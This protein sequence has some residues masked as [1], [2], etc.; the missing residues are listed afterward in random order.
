L[1]TPETLLLGSRLSLGFELP[2][3]GQIELDAEVAYQL[4][5]DLGVVFNA[6]SPGVR[7]AIGSF[8]SSALAAL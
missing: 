4:I 8:V 6:T 5:P 2:R 1:R 3:S 7:E